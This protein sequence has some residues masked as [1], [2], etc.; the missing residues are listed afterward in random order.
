MTRGKLG[1][2]RRLNTQCAAVTTVDGPTS[3]AVHD[4]RRLIEGASSFPTARQGTA[5]RSMR[6]R[7]SW[8][9]TER[10]ASK[11]RVHKG[12]TRS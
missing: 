8:A 6:T 12:K 7:G 4:A 2:V 3:V 10:P 11:G 9:P 5:S 1:C